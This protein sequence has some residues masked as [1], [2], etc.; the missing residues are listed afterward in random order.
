MWTDVAKMNR[1]MKRVRIIVESKDGE[2]HMLKRRQSRKVL[3]HEALT[4][5]HLAEVHGVGKQCLTSVAEELPL[6]DALEEIARE[7]LA[8]CTEF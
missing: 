8:Y 7:P 6:S 1:E 4:R 5:E 2:G 3:A